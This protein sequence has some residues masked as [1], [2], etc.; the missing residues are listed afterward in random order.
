MVTHS[1]SNWCSAGHAA[2]YLHIRQA[3]GNDDGAFTAYVSLVFGVDRRTVSTVTLREVGGDDGVEV[4]VWG[5]DHHVENTWR[6][7]DQRRRQNDGSDHHASMTA[8]AVVHR[9]QPELVVVTP[10]CSHTLATNHHV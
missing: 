5:A 3:V 8:A 1:S 10:R 2:S 9:H 4:R 7:N 6:Q